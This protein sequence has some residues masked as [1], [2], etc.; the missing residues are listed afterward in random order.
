[1]KKEEEPKIRN[2]VWGAFGTGTP[3][4]CAGLVEDI[5]Y[6]PE[7]GI[8]TK[9][10]GCNYLFKGFPDVKI[11]DRIATPKKMLMNAFYI[12]KEPIIR[13][14]LITPVLIFLILPKS[15]K[16]KVIDVFKNYFLSVSLTA[17]KN[18][19]LKEDRYK[20]AVKEIFRVLG[21]KVGEAE[22]NIISM[23]IEFDY[24]YLARFQDTFQYLNKENLKEN[25]KKELFRIIDILIEREI[26]EG[27]KNKWR[28]IKSF[29]KIALFFKDVRHFLKSVLLELDINK[30]RPDEGDW[31]FMLDRND[32]NYGGLEYHERM[33]ISKELDKKMNNK[34]P[35]INFNNE[36]KEE[37]QKQ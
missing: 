33:K 16:R 8:F 27:M 17:L 6:P 24:A 37:K 22:R 29:L 10:L 5:T 23:M 14:L 20:I 9:Y 7:G 36:K 28:S 1:M 25:F 26:G 19:F 21:S 3:E 32:F 34:R 35:T 15:Q 18:Q 30:I 31:Y 2:I 4:T 13:F 11:V 12:I